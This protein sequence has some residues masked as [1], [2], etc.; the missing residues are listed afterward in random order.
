MGNQARSRQWRRG[1]LAA[2][3]GVALAM[4]IAACGSS[5]G[6]AAGSTSSAAATS[7]GHSESAAS[8]ASSSAASGSSMGSSSNP[9]SSGTESAASSSAGSSAAGSA[10]AGTTAA[11]VSPAVTLQFSQW[12]GAELPSG[13]LD[14]IVKQ[15]EAENPGITIQL[16]TNPYQ[17][18]HDATIAAAA[19]HNMPDIVAMDGTWISDLQSQ[20]ALANLS[21][22]MK[23][24]NYD[25]SNLAGE[26]KVDGSAYMI[27][28]VNFIYP[29]FVNMDLL[30]QAGIT[31]V[32]TNR[33]EVKAAADAVSKKTSAK[34][35]TLALSPDTANGVAN[36]VMSWVWASGGTMLKPDGT[37]NINNP[38]VQSGVEFL[39]S[40]VDAGDITSGY[41]NT[42]ESEKPNQF[43]QG[44]TAMMVDSLAHITSIVKANPKLNFQVT[45]VPAADSYTGEKGI[46]S[47]AWG[48]G[49]SNDSQ[50]KDLAWRF[51]QYLMGQEVNSKMAT[52]ANAFPGNKTS[53]PDLSNADPHFK[54]AFEMYK[55]V[56]PVNEFSGGLP[57]PQQL[58][59]DFDAELQKYFTNGQSVQDA[60]ANTQKQWDTHIKAATG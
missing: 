9:A 53:S 45:S 39:K 43:A 11:P 4:V 35:L 7:A 3:A 28:V 15:F 38:D 33:T 49:I 24:A 14:A 21:D 16:V 55:T 19:T 22:L 25:D 2:T 1:G 27:P 41:L 56:K 54:A 6:S 36:D 30:K 26:L 59:S 58:Q 23:A 8:S 50:H 44:Q 46:V 17:N 52:L 47:A 60:L 42:Q 20:G 10:A 29:L 31:A 5:G 37:T 13:S 32:P 40:L 51:V 57:V 34:G 12:W 18:T 48:I